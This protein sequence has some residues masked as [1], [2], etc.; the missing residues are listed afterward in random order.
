M[1]EIVIA[2][3]LAFGA[4][5]YVRDLAENWHDVLPG[6]GIL[7]ALLVALLVKPVWLDWLTIWLCIVG[8][9]GVVWIG[10]LVRDW[11]NAR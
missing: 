2:L 9:M 7:M 3:A 6:L 4:I 1:I 11:R 8:L 5:Y 10:Q